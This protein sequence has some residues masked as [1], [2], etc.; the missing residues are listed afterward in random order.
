MI[1]IDTETTD[2]LKPDAAALE[3]QP[4][5]TEIYAVKLTNEN[6]NF[7][8]EFHSL[9]DIPIPV[10]EKITK[11]TGITDAM[12]K[13]KPK[14][15]EVYDAL[16]N[17]FLGEDTVVGH[18]ISFDMGVIRHELRRIEKQWRFP[19]PPNWI[20]TIEKS[21]HLRGHRLNLSKLHTIVTGK[22]HDESH[23]AE[24]DVIATV[25]CYTWLKERGHI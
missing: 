17:F 20:C 4:H 13:G 7:I 6:L 15:R 21:M 12:L 25:R 1:F 5:I 24:G 22:P 11:M 23:R 19:W 3:D 18:N 14:F 9:F 16:A 10:P 8:S 2:L